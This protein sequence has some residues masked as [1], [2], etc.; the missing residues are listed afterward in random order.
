MS[1]F[2]E[3]ILRDWEEI[4][5]TTMPFG[6][7]GPA[8]FPPHGM[9]IYNLP[10]EYLGWFAAKGGFPRG[11]LGALLQMVYHMKVEGLDHVFDALRDGG[12]SRNGTSSGTPAKSV[13]PPGHS[14]PKT[15]PKK[16]PPEVA[17]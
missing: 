2:E 4:G 10:V 6:K 13:T 17:S 9:P 15:P 7:F 1:G 3:N 11:R 12:K 16:S 14:A 8:H 5:R